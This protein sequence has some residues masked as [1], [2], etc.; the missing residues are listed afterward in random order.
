MKVLDRGYALVCDTDGRVLP[1]AEEAGKKDEMLLRF[2][3][4][5][6]AVNRKEQG[7]D[8]SGKRNL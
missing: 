1:T 8:G 2:R 3:D 4:G 7:Q 5:R 6:L